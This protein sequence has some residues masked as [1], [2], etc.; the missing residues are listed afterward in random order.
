M[1]GN[2]FPVPEVAEKIESVTRGHLY[3]DK[4]P[5]GEENGAYQVETFG[6]ASQ[7]YYAVMNPFTEETLAVFE[8]YDPDPAAFAEVLQQGIDKALTQ[9]LET[10][11][12]VTLASGG[13]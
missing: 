3:V 5:H 7:P 11:P 6:V 12:L 1:E 9:G 10:I 8:G 13:E 4:P 2:I